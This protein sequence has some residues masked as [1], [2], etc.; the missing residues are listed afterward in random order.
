MLKAFRKDEDSKIYSVYKIIRF[1]IISSIAI[2]GLNIIP[3]ILFG[4]LVS[5]F[6]NYSIVLGVVCGTLICVRV[7]EKK[8]LADSGFAF[9]KIDIIYFITGIFMVIILN[10]III[11]IASF[12]AGTNL[13]PQLFDK[14]LQPERN[15]FTFMVIPLSEEL[16][17]RG[18]ILNNTFPKLKFMHRSILSALLFSM[19]HWSNTDSL[20]FGLFIFTFIF[21]TFIF[22]LFFNLLAFITKSIWCGFGFHW[23]YNF[24]GATLFMNTSNYNLTVI[25]TSAFLVIGLFVLK[26]IKHM[27]EIKRDIFSA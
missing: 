14:V 20:S 18:Y 27:S 26:K 7:I 11:S 22:G 19:T 3:F 6:V 5:S 8:K 9:R 2:I 15:I 17:Y 10:T 4:K 1:L 13:F 21:C 24:V 23:F 12:Q 25:T 16:I